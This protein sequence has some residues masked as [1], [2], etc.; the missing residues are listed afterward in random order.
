MTLSSCLLRLQQFLR[1]SLFL[2]TTIL[3][4]ICVYF[5]E[6]A[7]WRSGWYFSRGQTGVMGV[8]EEDPR[9]KAPFLSYHFKGTYYQHDSSQVTL[10]IRLRSHLPGFSTES[11][12]LFISL[13]KLCSLEGC[14]CGQDPFKE[15]RVML[16]AL[17]GGEYTDI[18]WNSS[19]WEIWEVSY[20]HI[21]VTHTHSQIRT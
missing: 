19:G 9:E 6:C 18:I 1:F 12:L 13:S 20:K 10:I 8:G 7:Q 4:C 17:Q 3:R 16:Q 21:L 5:A 11:A 14:C 15:R 2:K